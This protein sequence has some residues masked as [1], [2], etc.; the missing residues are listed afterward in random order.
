MKKFLIAASFVFALISCNEDSAVNQESTHA[1]EI[2]SHRGC[3]SHEVLERQI[4]EDPDFKANLDNLEAFT[5]RAIAEGRLV[6][7]VIQIPVVV[8][9]LYK[10]NSENISLSQIQSQIDVLNKDFNGANSDFNH[11]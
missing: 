9:V 7:G 5:D 3:A 2:A 4:Q 6:N 8:N 11:G 10:T 1:N